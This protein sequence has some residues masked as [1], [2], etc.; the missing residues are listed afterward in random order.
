MGQ[1]RYQL[2]AQLTPPERKGF[3]DDRPWSPRCHELE[4]LR[5]L[6]SLPGVIHRTPAGV[7]Q[8]GETRIDA[9]EHRQLQHF[10]GPERD[11]RYRGTT[12]HDRGGIPVCGRFRGDRRNPAQMSG[13][14]QVLRIEQDH[15]LGRDQTTGTGG[16]E[17]T[18]PADRLAATPSPPPWQ[19]PPRRAT[20]TAAA[21]G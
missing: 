11:L 17:S 10:R 4:Q 21:A 18:A 2:E 14:E 12:A 6:A 16:Q 19:D 15:L 20:T 5:R 9:L 13:S 1:Q 7:D 3:D 8:L